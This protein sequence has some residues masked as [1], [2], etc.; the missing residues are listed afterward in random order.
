MRCFQPVRCVWLLWLAVA[1]AGCIGN[2]PPVPQDQPCVSDLIAV[3]DILTVTFS[4]LPA[5]VG[6]L[7]PRVQV[8]E[9]LTISLPYGV[10]VVAA[11][12]KFGQ[13]EKEIWTNYVPTTFT[14]V[15]ISVKP[16]QRW[17]SVGGEVKQPGRQLHVGVVRILQAIQGAGDFTDFS[18]RKKVEIIRADG[19]HQ[20]IDCIKARRDQRLNV[21]ICPGD[22][23][24][25]P[26]RL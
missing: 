25:V 12:K 22:A 19:R 9:D 26:R 8:K 17:Y 6:V 11:G 24:H 10:R 1:L 14:Q 18:N 2:P 4:D 21:L 7:E 15:T 16:E 13:L 3:G 20:V 23:I 5:A